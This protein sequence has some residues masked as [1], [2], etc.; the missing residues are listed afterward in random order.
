LIN[1]PI[2]VRATA[3]TRARYQRLAPMYDRM[4]AMSERR[5]HPWRQRLWSLVQGPRVLEVGV[6]TG[7]NMPFWPHAAEMTA[8]D[9]TPG[10]LDKA[11]QRAA[12][13]KIRA[14]LRLGDVQ[15]LQFPDANFDTAV[16]TFVFCSVPDPALGLR[17]LKRVVKPGGQVILLEHMRSPNEVIGKIMD[18]LNPLVVR[19]MGANINRRTVENIQAAGWSIEQQDDLGMGG[20]V[21]IIVARA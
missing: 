10:M 6:G 18:V 17:E 14:D 7:K 20:I 11:Q 9:L 3:T 4:E 12:K 19:V 16:A 13:L 21:K 5:F 2:D 8:I 1:T 15:A